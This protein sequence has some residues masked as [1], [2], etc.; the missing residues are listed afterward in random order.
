M[1]REDMP[2]GFAMT[3]ALNPDAMKKFAMLS[4]AE[5]QR[6]VDGAHGVHSRQE[7]HQYVNGISSGE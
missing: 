6:I 7:M 4:D 1:K 3:M 2:I 5:Q